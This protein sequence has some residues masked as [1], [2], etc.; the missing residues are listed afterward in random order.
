MNPH[1]FRR[2]LR[3]SLCL[4]SL[5]ALGRAASDYSTPYVFTTLAGVASI[6]STD[7]TGDVARFNFPRG[8]ALDSAG[9]LYVADTEN[10]TIRKISAGGVVSTLAGKAGYHIDP[11][12]PNRGNGTGANARFSEPA[13]VT[14]DAAGNVFVAGGSDN[15]IR[16]VSSGGIVTTVAGGNPASILNVPEGV[17]VDSSGNLY[18]ADT[19]N[20]SIRRITSAGVVSL[21]AGGSFGSGDGTGAA[22]QFYNPRGIAL[23]SAGSLYVADSGNNTIR[24]IS[25]A[26]VVSTL[27]GT[28][29]VTGSADGTGAAAQFN[30]PCGVAVDAAGNLFVTDSGNSTIRKITPAGVVTTLAGHAGQQGHVDGGAATSRFYQPQGVAVDAA[31]N[32]Y[33]ADML[34]HTVRK[35]TSSGTTSTLA[36]MSTFLSAGT[37]D[38]TG[39]AA[40]FRRVT[41]LAMAPGG[42][43][44]LTDSDSHTIRRVT[45]AGVVTTVAGSADLSGTADGTG[46][47]ARFL[48]P[49]GIAVDASGNLYVSDSGNKRLRVITPGTVVTT[50]AGGPAGVPGTANGTGSAASFTDPRDIAPDFTGN[51]FVADSDRIRR[52]TPAGDVTTL[53]V[54]VAGSN[55][56]ATHYSFGLAANIAGNLYVAGNYSIIRFPGATGAGLTMAGDEANPS[57][58]GSDGIGSAAHFNRPKGLAADAAGNVYVADSGTETIRRISSIGKVVTLGGLVG[59]SG[60]ADGAGS[61]ARFDF[62]EAVAVDAAGTVYVGSGT[63]IRKGQPAGVPVITAQPSSQSVAAGSSVQL[64]VVASAVPAPTYQW[65]LNG[66]ALNGATSSVLSLTNVQMADAGDYTVVVSNLLGSVTSNKATLTVTTGTGT[67]PTNLGSGGGGGGGA[68]SLWFLLALL[69]LGAGRIATTRQTA[70]GRVFLH[71]K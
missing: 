66:S 38:G 22:A 71:S 36:G 29:G 39:S 37:A 56:P 11:N 58:D 3:G 4:L 20:Q 1:S 50:L 7:G 43:V 28:A 69:A 31:G 64:S 19:F 30:F 45:A 33:V 51:F 63:T 54:P 15:A 25:P 40:R 27:A 52:V 24:K 62:P 14:V 42:D 5:A 12:D 6:G 60:S 55:D 48:V 26:G 47:A 9:N 41:S 49:D 70:G 67:P 21:F 57:T 8:L 53:T 23:D 61:E 59:V 32:V 35:V 34:D 44:Y 65:Y 17:V 16:K 2:L 13:G 18:V 68:P 46:S 10:H